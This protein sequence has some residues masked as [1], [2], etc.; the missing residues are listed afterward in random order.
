[1]FVSAAPPI[2]TTEMFNE[3]MTEAMSRAGE[4]SSSTPETTFASK[5]Y[6]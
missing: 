1:M 4:Q 6:Y 3:A 2:I 5:C